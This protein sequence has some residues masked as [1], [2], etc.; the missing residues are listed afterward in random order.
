MNRAILVY[1]WFMLGLIF[2]ATPRGQNFQP[3]FLSSMEIPKEDYF[4]YLWDYAGKIILFLIIAE[5][6]KEYVN[7]FW[8]MFRFQIFDTVDYMCTYNSVWFHVGLIP[9]SAN[10]VGFVGLGLI[11]LHDH[12]WRLWR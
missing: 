6:S 9:V 5:E 12:L 10:T 2:L 8:W 11:L 4:Y 7:Y 1:V 3:F